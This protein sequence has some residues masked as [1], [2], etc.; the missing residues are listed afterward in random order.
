MNINNLKT[1]KL[2]TGQ[3]LNVKSPNCKNNSTGNSNNIKVISPAEKAQNCIHNSQTFLTPHSSS[4]SPEKTSPRKSQ[5]N[6]SSFLLP[7]LPKITNNKKKNNN[8]N[9]KNNNNNNNNSSP[10]TVSSPVDMNKRD[11]ISHSYETIEGVLG[12]FLTEF[13]PKNLSSLHSSFSDTSSYFK[14]R[15]HS[16]TS[17]DLFS[18]F[19][20]NFVPS[21]AI[22]F[23][24]I[25]IPKEQT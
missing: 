10:L 20:S 3:I 14:K 13:S 1:F 8:N 7:P 5:S 9:N 12:E 15:K 17:N 23:S 24:K 25:E 2:T 11:V 4:H 22:E 19:D 16:P 21:S 18:S 6:P